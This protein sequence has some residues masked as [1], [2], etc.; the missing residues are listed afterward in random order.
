MRKAI[1]AGSFDPITNGH[2]WVMRRGV[3]LFDEV[4]LAIA[5]NDKKTPMFTLEER[6]EMA[7]ETAALESA[8]ISI[9]VVPDTKFAATYANEVKATHMLRGIRNETDYG[10]ERELRSVNEKIAFNIHMVYFMPPLKYLEVSS[11]MV[12]SLIGKTGWEDIVKQY[13]PPQVMKR[14]W[15]KHNGSNNA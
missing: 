3:E 5:V 14:L 4:V 11:S 2:T 8:N 13:V 6:L 1:Y 10:F 7:Q 9:A 12:K 15:E